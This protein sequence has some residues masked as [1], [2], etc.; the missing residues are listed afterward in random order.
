MAKSYDFSN[1]HIVQYAI[2]DNGNIDPK[3]SRQ[4]KYIQNS[5]IS[6]LYFWGVQSTPYGIRKVKKA[7]HIGLF[8]LSKDDN[9]AQLIT[10]EIPQEPVRRQVMPVMGHFLVLSASPA[11]VKITLSEHKSYNSAKK[12]MEDNT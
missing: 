10:F 3:W 11:F 7:T 4:L 9:Q 1:T 12:S 2:D 6:G 8:D 5:L